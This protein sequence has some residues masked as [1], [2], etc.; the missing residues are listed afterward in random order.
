MAR[1]LQCLRVGV[2]VAIVAMIHWQHQQFLKIHERQSNDIRLTELFSL[3]PKASHLQSPT[4]IAGVDLSPVVDRSGACIGYVAK[5]LPTARHVIGFSGP[6]DVLLIFDVSQNLIG[7]KLLESRDTAEHVSSVQRDVEFFSSFHGKSISELQSLQ[8]ID[9]VSGATLTSL[10]I[11]EAIRWR[12]RPN[13]ST[14]GLNGNTLAGSVRFPRHPELKHIRQVFPDANEIVPTAD[15][16]TL[17]TIKNEND[18]VLG[19]I[20]RTSPASDNVIGYQGPTDALIGVDQSSHVVGVTVGES[21]DNEPYVGYVRGDKYFRHVFDR[22][23]VTELAE[24]DLVALGIEGVSGATMTSMAV[25]DGIV[26]ASRGEVERA[27]AQAGKITSQPMGKS[28]YWTLRNISTACITLF[29]L[30]LGSTSL[31]S[32]KRVRLVYQIIVI[33]WLGL[34][35]G[36]LVS[37][38]LLLGWAQQG[39]VWKHATGLALLNIAALVAPIATG[40]NVYCGHICPHGAVQQ[41]IRQR[42]P[43]RLKI[44]ARTALLLKVIPAS[45]LSLVVAIG[46]LHLPLSPVA[47][48]PFD[49]WIWTVAGVATIGVALVGLSFS[50]FVPMGYC[51]YGCP[52]GALINYVRLSGSSWSVRDTAGILTL[53][54]AIAWFWFC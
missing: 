18:D 40:K 36:D 34:L 47:I 1:M 42:V 3:L 11:A 50:V 48:E 35:N 52:T 28:S 19:Q 30:C 10:A 32:R 49:A 7:T 39:I 8:R 46:L 44:S 9:G 45:L 5:T 22:L 26:L 6:S 38:A 16:T 33:G 29:G 54:L 41:L 15:G 24:A 53:L 21:F 51:R 25:A 4:E 20:L 43:W 13:D 31:R 2:F 23:T 17:W 12:L 37:Q 27:R 14:S